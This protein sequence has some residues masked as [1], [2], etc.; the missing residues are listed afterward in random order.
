MLETGHTNDWLAVCAIKQVFNQ[1]GN[2]AKRTTVK[3]FFIN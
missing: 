2:S 1:S 3:Y